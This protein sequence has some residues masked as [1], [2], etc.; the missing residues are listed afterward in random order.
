MYPLKRFYEDDVHDNPM[1]TG[2]S[3]HKVIARFFPLWSL[4]YM[5]GTTLGSVIYGKAR[6]AKGRA[7]VRA[8]RET[9][10]PRSPESLICPN[11]YEVLERITESKPRGY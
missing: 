10:L 3:V 7:K 6:Q 9:I 4:V 2:N 1:S 5:V 11:C 8:A